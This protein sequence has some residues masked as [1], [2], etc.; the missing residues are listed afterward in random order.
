M[1]E[2]ILILLSGIFGWLLALGSYPFNQKGFEGVYSLGRK[3]KVT[4]KVLGTISILYS[5]LLGLEFV[6]RAG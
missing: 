4:L 2:M 3:Y 6:L 1:L 5:L